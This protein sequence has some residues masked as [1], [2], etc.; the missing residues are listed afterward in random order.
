MIF[1]HQSPSQVKISIS[2]YKVYEDKISTNSETMSSTCRFELETSVSYT[3][4]S[5]STC[6]V[7]K[8]QTLLVSNDFFYM[9]LMPISVGF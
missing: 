6:L 4:I 8:A 1:H 9:V 3:P 7:E 2:L 5:W